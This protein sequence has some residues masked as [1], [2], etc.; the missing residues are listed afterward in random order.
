MTVTNNRK[1]SISEP[2]Q[3]DLEPGLLVECDS[4]GNNITHSVHIRC[5][6]E[7]CKITNIDLC[8]RCFCKGKEVGKHKAW[9]PY[10][11]IV[12]VPST[13]CTA[14]PAHSRVD[15]FKERHSYPIFTEDWGA[16]EELLL[17]DGLLAN[18]MGSWADAAEHIGTRSR[19]ESERHYNQVYVTSPDWPMPNMD[20]KFDFDLEEFQTRKKRRLEEIGKA[21]IEHTVS[22]KPLVSAPTNHEIAGF[23]P[24]RLEFETEVENEAEEQVKDMEFGLVMEYG[25]EDQPEGDPPAAIMEAERKAANEEDGE[26]D[27]DGDVKMEDEDKSKKEDEEPA[28]PLGPPPVESS[29]S[30]E[31]KLCLLAIYNEKINRRL[32]TKAV[33]FDRGLLEMK[34]LQAIERKRG[35]TGD[36]EKEKK[37]ERDFINKHKPFARLQTASDYET[38]VEGLLYEVSLRKRIQE[39]QEYR[40]MG[41]TTLAEAEKYEKDKVA[42]AQGIRVVPPLHGDES[43]GRPRPS[44]LTLATSSSLQLLTPPEQLLCSQLRILPKPYLAI[45]EAL[46]REYIKKGGKLR[47]RD[48][49]DLFKIDKDKTGKIYDFLNSTGAFKP[50]QHAAVAQQQAAAAAIAANLAMMVNGTGPGATPGPAG[51]T[52]ANSAPSSQVLTVPPLLAPSAPDVIMHS[53]SQQS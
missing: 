25:G 23:M 18:G 46:L 41:I 44:V 39:L 43:G 45:K 13:N 19:E 21:P 20:V 42:R 36:K 31:L 17:I 47:K 33:V 12:S 4:C 24:G 29:A 5:A 50:V 14:G 38:F 51:S 48:A 7:E 53:A 35:G 2:N 40:R 52:P 15:Q 34:K 32:E 9:H 11:V 16:D 22:S 37:A 28:V 6:A 1:P 3:V 10:R 30:L 8:P 26:G 27:G 49:R